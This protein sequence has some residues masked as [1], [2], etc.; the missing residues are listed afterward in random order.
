MFTAN[1]KTNSLEPEREKTEMVAKEKSSK[2]DPF[3]HVC[4]LVPMSESNFEQTADL[5]C[6]ILPRNIDD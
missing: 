6:Y 3:V 2:C 4:G 1:E 5:T